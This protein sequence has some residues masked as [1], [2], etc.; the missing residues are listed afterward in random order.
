M[1]LFWWRSCRNRFCGRQG[2]RGSSRQNLD[3]TADEAKRFLAKTP[4]PGTHLH[5]PGGLEGKLATDYGVMVLPQL[6]L[7]DKEG[8]VVNRNAQVSTLEDEIKKLL[9]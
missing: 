8:K 6:F 1:K 5:Q 4:G 7:L 9:K 2:L 3:N